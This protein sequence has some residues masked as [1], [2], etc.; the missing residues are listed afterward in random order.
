MEVII[1]YEE[2]VRALL[3][4]LDRIEHQIEA[5]PPQVGEALIA[6]ASELERQ[7]RVYRDYYWEIP[8]IFPPE[9]HVG[10]NEPDRRLFTRSIEDA[11]RHSADDAPAPINL[12]DVGDNA[13]SVAATSV[14]A[15]GLDHLFQRLGPPPDEIRFEGDPVPVAGDGGT[16]R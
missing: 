9:S 11:M 1:Q 7:I 15:S 2:R 14:I 8:G 16:A 6:Q 3:E 5:G 12:T 4:Q 13:D 10:H